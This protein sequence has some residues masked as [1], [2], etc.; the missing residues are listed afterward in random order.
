MKHNLG[1]I[2]KELIGKM[3]Y[4]ANSRYMFDGEALAIIVTGFC[5]L[6]FVA[7]FGVYSNWDLARHNKLLQEEL[8]NY[9]HE[10][11]CEINQRNVQHVWPCSIVGRNI[12][13][14]D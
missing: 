9:R 5:V 6:L 8:D 12:A 3:R 2:I 10:I 4:F 14:L 1:Y 13:R 7:C 11:R